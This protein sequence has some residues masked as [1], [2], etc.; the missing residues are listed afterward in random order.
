MVIL[1]GAT[2][3]V[4]ASAETV[5]DIYSDVERWPRWTASMTSVRRLDSG[6]LAVGSRA[7]VRQPRLPPTEW[8]VTDLTP[9]RSFTWESRR[10]G[11]RSVG[12]HLITPESDR[13]SVTAELEHRGPLAAVA[14]LVTGRLARRYLDWETAGLKQWCE[15]SAA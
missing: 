1:L 8:V 13:C 6:P 4:D 10:P 9:G 14:G 5:F 2:V 15:Q 3:E 7:L 11:V 12:R